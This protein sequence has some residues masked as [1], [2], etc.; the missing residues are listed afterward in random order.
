MG[1]LNNSVEPLVSGE[2]S[3]EALDDKMQAGYEAMKDRDVAAACRIWL[4]AW[5][6]VVGLLDKGGIRSIEDFDAQFRGTQSLF[7]WIQ[8]LEGELWNAGLKDRQF[9]Q[10]RIAFCAEGVRRFEASDDDLMM[11]NRRRALAESY[12]KL[13][14]SEKA[15]AL[16]REWLKT[17]PKWGWGWIGWSDCH[18]F[19][20]AQSRDLKRAEQLLLEG[21]A[22][23]QVRDSADIRRRL[24]D[25]Y[26]DQGRVE[27]AEQVRQQVKTV[28]GLIQHTLEAHP[29]VL[30]QKTTI[31]FEGEG[32]PLDEMPKA[33]HVLRPPSPPSIRSGKKTGRNEPCPCGSGKKFKKCCGGN[34]PAA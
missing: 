33:G 31:T 18:Q 25:L 20:D 10:A 29:D 12:V 1:L 27:E 3:F 9:F 11:G 23:A 13:G 26:Q 4:D 22:V 32:L 24:A 14:E 2:P 30:Q 34:Q 8:D 17:D 28:S 6:D 16:F 15:E 7:N 5:S 21:L 19:T